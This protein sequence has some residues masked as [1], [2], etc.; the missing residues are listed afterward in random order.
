[1]KIS[2]IIPTYNRADVLKKNVI[3]LLKQKYADLEIIVVDD[4]S[5]PSNLKI[6]KEIRD[7]V[8]I[9]NI[10]R[11]PAA[12]RNTAIKIA[13]G[14]VLIFIN[15]DTEVEDNFLKLHKQFHQKHRSSNMAVLGPMLEKKEMTNNAA[16]DWL[17]N[18]SGQHFN[19][20]N[21]KE[22][23][24]AP[25]YYFW[26]CNVSIKRKFLIDNELFFDETFPTAAWEDI[27]L[28]FRAKEKGL[29]L[30]Y[31]KNI[32]CYHDHQFGFDEVFARF[33]SHGRGLYHIK[34]KLPKNFLPLLTN[35]GLRN[36]I[37]LLL[38]ISQYRWWSRLLIKMLKELNVAPNLIMQIL[39]V[40][41]KIEG[42]EYEKRLFE[43]KIF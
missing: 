38:T 18:V 7:I 39:I 28:A 25:W 22:N 36:F 11:G 19:Y 40:G 15:D 27:E 29:R 14:D 13:N 12:A 24:N 30:F 16:I 10:H 6:E 23:D 1:M 17:V 43:S 8:L 33:Y 3:R 4:G 5:D 9:K 26:T 35:S 31:N 32:G 41:K 21:I 2:V 42:Y 37:K 34:D 20:K